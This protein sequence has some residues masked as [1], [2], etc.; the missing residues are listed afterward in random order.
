MPAAVET[1]GAYLAAAGL[2]YATS[3]LR[4][5]FARAHRIAKEPLDTRHPAIH[6]SLRGIART[7]GGWLRPAAMTW[8]ASAIAMVAT[9]PHGAAAAA[10]RLAL[11]TA[12]PMG[13]M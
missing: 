11:E 8:P 3:T 1:V 2:G 4:C 10:S 5:R 7:S 9:L 6:E 13:Y 12:P